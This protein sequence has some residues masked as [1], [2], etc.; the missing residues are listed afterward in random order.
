MLRSLPKSWEA[1]MTTIEKAKNLETL[2]LDEFIGSL[3]T[4]EMR[5]NEA[6]EEEKV[7]NKSIDVAIKSTTNDERESSDEI[8]EDKEMA[9]FSKRFKKFMKSTKGRIFQRKGG[10]KLESNKEKNS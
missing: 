5:L 8:D 1:K 10:L 2:I 9:M 7:E 4:H 6:V 3:L